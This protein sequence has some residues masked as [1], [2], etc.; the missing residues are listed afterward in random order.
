MNGKIG[1]V[2]LSKIENGWVCLK[3]YWFSKWIPADFMSVVMM[4]FSNRF[5]N[6]DVIIRVIITFCDEI[7]EISAIF[8]HNSHT[9]QP[10][11]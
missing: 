6:Y 9:P 1:P 7:S 10:P 3:E 4:S 5:L 2:D 8:L 11:I